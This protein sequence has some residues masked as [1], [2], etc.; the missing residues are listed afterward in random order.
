MEIGSKVTW[1]ASNKIMQGL[2]LQENEG[3]A[4]IICYQM[5]QLNCHLRVFVDINAIKAV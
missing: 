1:E 4:E 5:G 2:F 3:I